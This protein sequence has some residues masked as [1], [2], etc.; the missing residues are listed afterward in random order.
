LF[1]TAAASSRHRVVW[2]DLSRQLTA[3]ALAEERE[4]DQIP[5]NTCYVIAA[6][7]L[8]MALRL[9]AWLNSTWSR[10]AARVVAPPAASG[11]LRF[12]AQVVA[13]LPL[14]DGVLTDATLSDLA[15]A[16]ARGQ[17]VQ[18]DLDAHTARLLGLT[19]A[20]AASLAAVVRRAETGR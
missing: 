10:A 9:A 16:G 1:R 7:G 8:P 18:R 14:P 20:D 5:L 19:S 13:G 4:R 12:T 15:L 3:V 11:F 2:A 17:P 6:E